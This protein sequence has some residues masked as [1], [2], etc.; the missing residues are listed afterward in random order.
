MN[1]LVEPDPMG[2][3]RRAPVIGVTAC[4]RESSFGPWN[5][6]AVI[7]PSGYTTAIEEAGGKPLLLPPGCCPSLLDLLDGLVVAGGPD[8]NPSLYGQKPSEHISL[9]HPDQDGS[10][11][12]LIRGAVDRDIPL[13][14]ICRGMQLMCVVHGGK[15]HQH[16]PET[17]GHEEHGGWDGE[18][19]EHGV[20]TV[21]GTHLHSIMGTTVSVNSTHHQGVFDPGSLSASAHS[22]HDG[23]IEGVERTDKRFCIGVQWHPE[24]IGHVG[25]YRALVDAARGS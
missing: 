17:P 24:R 15:I 11:A 21:E 8:I 5:L 1:S 6:E 19:T 7:L 14:G 9:A 23:L 10:E 3:S 22:S 2:E 25:L 4:K 13:L 12:D 16:L 18:V 20:Q